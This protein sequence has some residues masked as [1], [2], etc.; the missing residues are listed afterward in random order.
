[1]SFLLDEHCAAELLHRAC[2]DGERLPPW[3]AAVSRLLT[4]D[5]TPDQAGSQLWLPALAHLIPP[6]SP[7]EQSV[8]PLLTGPTPVLQW[9]P[10]LGCDMDY[11]LQHQGARDEGFYQGLLAR[12]GPGSRLVTR[13]LGITPGSPLTGRTLPPEQL[14]ATL[15]AQARRLPFAD[16]ATQAYRLRQDMDRRLQTVL[17]HGQYI[18]GPEVGELEAKLAALAGT[19]HCVALSDGTAALQLALMALGI[20][21]GDEVIL[22]PHTFIATGEVIALLGAHPVFADIDPATFC[23]D[24]TAVARAITPRTRA[25]LPVSLYG[26]CADMDAL[27]ALAQTGRGAHPIAVIEDGAESFGARYR[28]RPSCGLSTLATTSFFP[29]KPLGCYG[30]GGACFT[31]DDSL[32]ETLRQLRAHGSRRRYHHARIGVNARMDTLQAAV[33]LAKLEAFPAEVHQREAL[34]RRFRQALSPLFRL[35]ALPADQTSTYCYFVI[36]TALR[37]E[38]LAHLQGAGI[39]CQ[40]HFPIPLHLQEAFAHL[41]HQAGDF[42]VAEAVAGT[43][44]SLPFSPWMGEGDITYLFDTLARWRAAHPEPADSPLQPD[45]PDFP[46]PTPQDSPCAA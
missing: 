42:P 11:L 6:A 23:L 10:L 31:N 43:V 18:L 30:D 29:A 20:G 14:P 39:A 41:G 4:T 19:T 1:M 16:L 12:L 5:A 9:L 17:H 21:P 8:A 34:A 38:L 24:P 46:G 26:Q 2:T 7:A 15:T 25:I 13:T 33:V 22:P 45:F 35:Q 28:E 27:N 32:A 40:V 37:D 3:F 36:R 44:L